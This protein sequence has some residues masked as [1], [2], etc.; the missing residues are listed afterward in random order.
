MLGPGA[1]RQ[2]LALRQWSKDNPPFSSHPDSESLESLDPTQR[3]ILE[4]I[5]SHPG[6][7]LREICRALTLAMGD[8]QYHIRRLERDGRIHSTRR[9]LYKFFYP[10]NLFGERQRDVLSVL[11]LD[12]PR[13]LLLNIIEHPES[14]Q[15]VLAG[16]T[17][18]S[19]P[20]VSWHLKR[21]VELGIVGRRQEGRVVTYS[22]ARGGEIAAFI[23]TYHPTV[24]ER[25]SSRLAD[26]FIAY[27]SEEG[28]E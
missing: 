1:R 28:K 17:H 27:S 12:R 22:I 21:L 5:A 15:E 8:V 18:V 9:G 24:W 3:R 20:T 19:Q 16:A 23:K 26:I 2:A 7:H 6:V 10:A 25:W 4:F 11:S 14:T 13:E